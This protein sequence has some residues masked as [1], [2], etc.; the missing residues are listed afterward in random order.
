VHPGRETSMHYQSCSGGIGM[1]S[2]KSV[3]GHVMLNLFF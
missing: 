1:D 3:S 2:T